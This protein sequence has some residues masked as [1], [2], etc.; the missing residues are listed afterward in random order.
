M[1]NDIIGLLVHWRDSLGQLIQHSVELRRIYKDCCDAADDAAVS[2]VFG[3]M[4]AAKHRVETFSTPL[5]RTILNLSGYI[6]TAV[7]ISIIRKGNREA[8]AAI[9]FLRA[10]CVVM[11]L[12][13][14]MMADGAG[15]VMIMIRMFDTEDVPLAAMCIAVEDLLDRLT[16]LFHKGGCFVVAGHVTF[17]MEWLREPHL[18]HQRRGEMH[19]RPASHGAAEG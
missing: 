19:W 8:A 16:W 9:T 3:N 1:L 15:V 5:S 14:G 7:K 12:I 2:T 17:I 6:A 18:F 13:A 11:L 10:L 4:R